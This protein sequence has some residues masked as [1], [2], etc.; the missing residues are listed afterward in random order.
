MKNRMLSLLIIMAL[1]FSLTACS[2]ND[3]DYYE[4]PSDDYSDGYEEYDDEEYSDSAVN[5]IE[6]A[7]IPY[8]ALGATYK[9]MY[10]YYHQEDYSSV[11]TVDLINSDCYGTIF[12]NM[13][14]V[15]VIYTY[16]G[17]E[18]F[19]DND[20]AFAADGWFSRVFDYES[21][22]GGFTAQEMADYLGATYTYTVDFE[23]EIDVPSN[24]SSDSLF[25]FD[26]VLQTAY[27]PVNVTIEIE[28]NSGDTYMSQDT[29]V[30][31]K[32]N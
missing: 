3:D 21:E 17:N 31:V 19:F 32:L 12:G 13:Q 28:A 16:T 5:Y 30:M 2:G 7:E 6:L 22:P 26:T 23:D 25:A 8:N 24:L 11:R 1:A 15:Y 14:N 4:G 18:P 20:Y 10:D 9:S 29:W 27:G